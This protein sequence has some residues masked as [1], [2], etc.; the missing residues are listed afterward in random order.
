M[1]FSK[2]PDRLW[3]EPSL[4]FIQYREFFLRGQSDWDVKLI[5]HL[6]VGPMYSMGGVLPL[7]LLFVGL[8]GATLPAFTFTET[9]TTKMAA[10]QSILR[11]SILTSQRGCRTF[12]LLEPRKQRGAITTLLVRANINARFC[13]RSWHLHLNYEVT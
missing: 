13:L 6:H 2:R 11:C 1:F 8:R 7:I 3:C 10:Q 5:T 4:L 12:N 9:E